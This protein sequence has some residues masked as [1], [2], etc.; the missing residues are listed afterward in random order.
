M[1][2]STPADFGSHD[3]WFAYVRSEIP[4]AKQP[5]ALAFG[6]TE[7]FREL[8]PNAGVYPSRPSSRRN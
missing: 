5:Y 2:T 1:S 8:L 7:L 3:E 6:R 4:V